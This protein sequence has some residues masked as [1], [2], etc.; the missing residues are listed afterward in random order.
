MPVLCQTGWP[1]SSKTGRNNQTIRSLAGSH[2]DRKHR[3]PTERRPRQLK[4]SRS[5][6]CDDGRG[7]I[8]LSDELV[9]V[10]NHDAKINVVAVTGLSPDSPRILAEK[11]ST[12]S[13]RPGAS[14]GLTPRSRTMSL[15][16]VLVST[17]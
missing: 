13:D 12:S 8:L 9:S 16:A 10:S 6:G 15:A 4:V 5:A 2:P 7:M 17:L 3:W 14:E 1:E 11:G